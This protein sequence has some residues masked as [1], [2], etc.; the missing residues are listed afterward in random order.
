[1]K[2]SFLLICDAKK[3]V[4]GGGLGKIPAGG[5]RDFCG[6][7][8]ENIGFE[9]LYLPKPFEKKLRVYEESYIS[10]VESTPKT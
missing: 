3:S 9:H 6:D 2:F 10:M 4:N 5:G 8:F 1:M 7:N